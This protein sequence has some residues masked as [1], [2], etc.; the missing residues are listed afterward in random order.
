MPAIQRS[1]GAALAACLCLAVFALAAP[2]ARAQG[3]AFPKEPSGSFVYFQDPLWHCT[4]GE[5]IEWTVTISNS[6]STDPLFADFWDTPQSNECLPGGVSE[7]VWEGGAQPGGNGIESAPQ[8]AMTF[9]D[10]NGDGNCEETV[11]DAAGGLIVCDA[12]T[13]T[14]RI[15]N[16]FVPGR[17]GGFPPRPGVSTIRFLTLV[18]AAAPP[19]QFT[20]NWAFVYDDKDNADPA[21]DALIQPTGDPEKTTFG[22]TCLSIDP[23]TQFDF[24]ASKTAL[25][26]ATPLVPGK[27]SST[28]VYTITATNTGGEDINGATYTDVLQPGQEWVDIVDCPAPLT[29]R[30]VAPDELQVTGWRIPAADPDESQTIKV[31][32]VVTCDAATDDDTGVVCNQGEFSISGRT[33]PTDDPALLGPTDPTCVPVVF[34]NLTESEKSWT[35]DDTDADGQLDAGERVRFRIDAINVGSLTAGSVV[36]TD[37][38]TTSPC[39]DPATIQAEDGGVVAG[40][41]VTWNLGDLPNAML[42]PQRLNVSAVLRT[43]DICCNQAFLQSVERTDC[44][45]DP[46]PTDDPAT[47]SVDDPTCAIPGPRPVLDIEKTWALEQDVDASGDLSRNDMISFTVTITNNGAGTA[48]NAQFTDVM[49][50]CYTRL[51]N[52]L[53]DGGP[54][55]RVYP[56]EITTTDGTDAGTDASQPYGGALNPGRVVVNDVGGA[57]GI[58]PGETVTI[59]FYVSAASLRCCNQGFLSYDEATDAQPTDDP[60]TPGLAN[61][62]TCFGLPPAGPD[63]A[64][65]K[66]V[67]LFDVNGDGYVGIGD[68]A[69]YTL[70]LTST[71]DAPLSNVVIVDPSDACYTLDESSIVV[72]G[73]AANAT[74]AGSGVVTVNATGPMDP[75]EVVTV[76][77]VVNFAQ[78]GNCCNQASFSSTEIASGVSNDPRDF[79]ADNATCVEVAVVTAPSFQLTLDKA[80]SAAGCVDPGATVDFTLTVT[81]TGADPVVTWSISDPLP[82]GFTNIVVAPPLTLAGSTVSLDGTALGTLAPAETRTFTYSARVPCTAQGT[83]TNTATVTYETALTDDASATVD[84][85]VP[86]LSTSVKELQSF[87]GNGNGWNE[88]GEDVQWRVAVTNTGACAARGVVVTDT[89]DP[90][91]D[92]ATLAFDPGDTGAVAGNV[93]TWDSTNVPELA[94]VAPGATVELIFRVRVV[95]TTPQGVRIGNGVAIDALNDVSACP[96]LPPVDV[97]PAAATQVPWGDQV[98]ADTSDLLRN[99]QVTSRFTAFPTLHSTVFLGRTPNTT[100]LGEVSLDRVRDLRQADVAGTLGAGLTV[101]GDGAANPATPVIFYEVSEWCVSTELPGCSSNRICVRK[102][103]ADVIVQA[104]PDPSTCR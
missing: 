9:L 80:S 23:P 42:F 85:G 40:G 71:G 3:Q 20:C 89:L 99:A 87:D 104:V 82:A 98:A 46:I 60:L 41:V 28:I 53:P 15:L 65:D 83:L 17:S 54:T 5:L 48:T 1:L 91:F 12:A 93:I 61:D 97:Q 13:Q 38:F 92:A 79:I 56:N 72:V 94:S 57:N 11:L 36:V 90:R 78:T 24:E 67:D 70:E 10:P 69:V 55:S 101:A 86:N 37:D 22:C 74:V 34:S 68:R 96:A 4:A 29:C 31:R 100:T 44:G 45:M 84:W 43:S 21:D 59:K 102:S 18:D 8:S 50:V 75:A 14:L 76:T 63:F 26:E 6:F 103:G 49:Q 58:L 88:A 77:F 47:I 73:E 2:S 35:W 32:A 62:S 25:A 30:I 16:A 33:F 27:A 81:N 52:A 7:R 51:L 95:T 39:F 19:S 66:S 64:F